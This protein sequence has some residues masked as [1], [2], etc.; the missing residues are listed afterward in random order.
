MSDGT[1][2]LNSYNKYIQKN[3]N[4]KYEFNIPSTITYNN[5]TYKVSV[6]GDN[7]FSQ[8][9]CSSMEFGNFAQV[10]SVTIPNTVTSIGKSAFEGLTSLKEI[11]FAEESKLAKIDEYAFARTGIESINI[12]NSCVTI[13]DF[14]FYKSELK[15]VELPSSLSYLGSNV[16]GG[17]SLNNVKNKNSYASFSNGIYLQSTKLPLCGC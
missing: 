13:D 7:V 14:A 4:D 1:A 15:D 9:L 8:E 11:N 17:C 2:C 5:I 6:L 10:E 3:E 12:P 16:F